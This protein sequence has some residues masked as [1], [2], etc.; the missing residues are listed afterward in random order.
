MKGKTLLRKSALVFIALALVFTSVAVSAEPVSAAS[1]K[2]KSKAYDQV[3][4]SKNTA[5]CTMGNTIKK[6]NLKTGKVTTLYKDKDEFMECGEMILKG[7]YLYFKS[8]CSGV[9]LRRVNVKTKKSKT[10]DY[11]MD[12][13]NIG[14]SGKKLYY[15]AGYGTKY[16]NKDGVKIVASLSGKNMKKTSV[17]VSQKKLKTNKK[18]YKVT[19]KATGKTKSDDSE[20]FKY[21][22][23][24]PGKDISLGTLWQ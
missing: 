4:V 24:K 6:V 9:I 7:D 21:T 22:L 17:K 12:L 15:T 23:V 19:R 11:G 2:I 16:P 5:Y 14:I 3:V 8:S 10:I 18:G 1:K 13:W 20:E